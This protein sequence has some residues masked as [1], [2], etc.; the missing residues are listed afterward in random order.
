MAQVF[1]DKGTKEGQLPSIRDVDPLHE[2]KDQIES[3]VGTIK[4]DPLFEGAKRTEELPDTRVG[5]TL[6]TDDA[7]KLES[8]TSM[9]TDQPSNP[10]SGGVVKSDVAETFADEYKG[11]QLQQAD[12][13]SSGEYESH[14]NQDE[15]FR[16][17][18]FKKLSGAGIPRGKPH[19]RISANHG[20]RG[21]GHNSSI[22]TGG[23]GNNGVSGLRGSSRGGI[24]RTGSGLAR[25]GS[26]IPQGSSEFKD[27]S[28]ALVDSE[29]ADS[30]VPPSSDPVEKQGT[31]ESF[32]EKATKTED[33]AG[34]KLS[35]AGET[36]S[37]N[38]RTAK[39]T[40]ADKATA[41]KDLVVEKAGEFKTGFVETLK[42]QLLPVKDNAG[43]S[44]KLAVESG[45]E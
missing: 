23:D 22:Q 3:G 43:G 24:A 28:A 6:L 36:I 25:T 11:N 20:N 34:E 39:D 7:H 19:Y 45:A 40:V 18:K 38:M 41:A 37:E 44:G 42:D 14:G 1:E 27:F 33:A 5:E 12:A 2:V 26:G 35:S 30:P 29:K 21:L 9:E 31:G 4:S 16:G 15:E 8:T 32:S 10:S 13:G 17:M